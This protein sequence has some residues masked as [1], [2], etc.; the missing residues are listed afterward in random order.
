MKL[1]IF[2]SALQALDSRDSSEP[3]TFFFEI[4]FL[5]NSNLDKSGQKLLSGS[6]TRLTI[7]VN[8][9]KVAPSNLI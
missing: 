7:K 6:N 1:A 2:N 3:K 9:V 4:L 8:K 5:R